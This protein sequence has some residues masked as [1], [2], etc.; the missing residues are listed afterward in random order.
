MVTK[1]K[2]GKVLSFVISLSLFKAF[3]YLTVY[4]ISFDYLVC[5]INS[6]SR[7]L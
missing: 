7:F 3:K 2:N 6:I 1:I 5:Y 4:F